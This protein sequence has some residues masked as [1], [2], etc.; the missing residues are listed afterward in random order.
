MTSSR[1]RVRWWLALPVCLF[2]IDYE[3]LWKKVATEGTINP[4]EHLN[5]INKNDQIFGNKKRNWQSWRVNLLLFF[6]PRRPICLISS[7]FFL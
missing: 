1:G 3:E 7:R 2:L 6:L 4:A 5:A